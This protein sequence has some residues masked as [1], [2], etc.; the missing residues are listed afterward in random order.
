MIWT[1]LGLPVAD[2]GVLVSERAEGGNRDWQ[3]T[4]SPEA[5]LG[6]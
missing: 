4:K 2:W 1:E 3:N 5:G 6:E